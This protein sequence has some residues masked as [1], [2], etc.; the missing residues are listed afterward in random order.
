MGA[1]LVGRR[2]MSPETLSPPGSIFHVKSS[3]RSS[4]ASILLARSLAGWLAG[5]QPE[6]PLGV[7]MDDLPRNPVKPAVE[8][9]ESSRFCLA[10][11]TPTRPAGK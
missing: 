7:Q 8:G 9:G 11:K 3:P 5:R 4:L 2:A 1:G 10:E 6:P